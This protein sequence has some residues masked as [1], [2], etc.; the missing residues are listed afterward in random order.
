[1]SAEPLNIQE[2]NTITGLIFAQLHKAFPG[3]EN[4]DRAG[5][6]KAMDVA[7]DDWSKHKLPSGRS[8]DKALGY[9]IG[10]LTRLIHQAG[11]E[12]RYTWR[13]GRG[14]FG[15]GVWIAAGSDRLV[16]AGGWREGSWTGR[17]RPRGLWPGG[18]QG[19]RDVA[20]ERRLWASRGKGEAD[21]GGGLDDAGAEL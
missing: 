5:I 15:G 21:A 8:F 9:T 14:E 12:R 6:A 19:R 11:R 20:E 13:W 10:W 18:H 16:G 3:L 7:G 2:F 17:Q 4:I 1:M